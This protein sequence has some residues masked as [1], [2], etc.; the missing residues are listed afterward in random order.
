MPPWSSSGRSMTTMSAFFTTVAA[1]ATSNPASLAFFSFG[2]PETSPTMTE[3][4]LSFRLFAWACPWLPYPRIAIV[5]PLSNFIFASCSLYMVTIFSPSVSSFFG[6]L[7]CLPRALHS[8]GDGDLAGPHDL[9]DAE[10]AQ[11]LEERLHLPLAPR[12]LD[13]VAAGRH[14]DDPGA[15]DVDQPQHLGFPLPV[16]VHLDEHEFP[17]DRVDAGEVDHFQDRDELVQLLQDLFDDLV[18]PAGDERHPGDLRVHRLRH[19][20]RFDVE[21]AAREQ[22]GDAAQDPE[23]VLHQDGNRVAHRVPPL[24][25]RPGSDQ[26]HL[27]QRRARGDHRGPAPSFPRGPPSPRTPPPASR[28]RGCGGGTSGNISLRRRAPATGGPSPA[29]RCSG[30]RPSPGSGTAP[31]WPVPGCSSGC[32]RRP[33]CRRRGAPASPPARRSPPGARSPSSPAPPRRGRCAA[34]CRCRTGRPT[35]GSGRPPWR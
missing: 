35:S 7:S 29:S 20:E 34:A 30:S 25:G 33:R 23:L 9:P 24:P 18:V 4:P 19:A 14:V 26:Q 13:R 2:P 12:H 5:F 15:E 28:S 11:H 21:P 27:G 10:G 32:C 8:A 22:A 1:S 16:G 17:V 31:P 3:N 6:I